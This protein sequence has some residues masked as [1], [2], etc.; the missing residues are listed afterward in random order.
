MFIQFVKFI[1][2]KARAVNIDSEKPVYFLES[3]CLFRSISQIGEGGSIRLISNINCVQRRFVVDETKSMGNELSFGY[4][5]IQNLQSYENNLNYALEGSIFNSGIANN[6]Q[7]AIYFLQGK[8][9][10]S[11]LNISKCFAMYRVALRFDYGS[12]TNILNYSTIDRNTVSEE[13]IVTFDECTGFVHRCNILNNEGSLESGCIYAHKSLVTVED[14]IIKG[15]S[16]DRLRSVTDSIIKVVHCIINRLET[17]GK[18]VTMNMTTKSFENDLVHFNE[19]KF[20][21]ALKLLPKYDCKTDIIRY[22]NVGS[23]SLFYQTVVY[24][25]I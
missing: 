21:R 3:N 16:N 11:C 12:T 1:G 9:L 20:A 6:A 4:F 7:E 10:A 19:E 18:V 13:D 22:Q 5:S 14:C 17:A 25:I 8:S 2:Y 24:I 15:N 23:L